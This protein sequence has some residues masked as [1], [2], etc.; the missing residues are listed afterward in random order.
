[1]AGGGGGGATGGGGGARGGSG[2]TAGGS[3]G[4]T[5]GGGAGGGA[6]G[7]Q[8]GTG[9][10][11]GTGGGCSVAG[12]TRVSVVTAGAEAHGIS[13]KPSISA[14]GRFV[15]FSSAAPD[16]VAGDTNNLIDIFVHDRM[17]GQTT[18]VSVDSTGAQAMG[19]NS[20]APAISADGRFVVFGSLA[21]NL[22]AADG[23]GVQDVFVHD[24]TTHA[25]TRVSVNDSGAE[26]D[27]IS[28]QPAISGDGRYVA[29]ASHATNFVN[30]ILATNIFVRDRTAGTTTLASVS[31]GGQPANENCFDTAISGDGQVVVF[32]TAAPLVGG[33]TIGA[34]IFARD[35][36]ANTTTRVSNGPTGGQATGTCS[37]PA[38]TPDGRYV[39]FVSDA[40]DL[41]ANDTNSIADIFLRDRT[42]QTTTRVSVDSAGAEAMG[43]GAFGRPALS[44]DAR[45][46]VFHG[47][48]ATV[49]SG[50]T[51]DAT[52]IFLRDRTGG[53][54]VRINLGPG[55][56]QATMSRD[57]VGAT[58]SADGTVIA[59]E[60][61]ATNL[62][63]ADGNGTSDVFVN[64]RACR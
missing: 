45:T 63:A 44:A 38:I 55:G 6:G 43:P 62:I 36:T 29:F 59:F 1:V 17:T 8:A 35:R 27:N 30:G 32:A 47:L 39:V 49:V 57:S 7:G 25:T 58:I 2:G 37:Q 3:G 24:L 51:N 54:T 48:S 20:S 19:G 33:V 16:L 53:T 60:S 21:T 61:T 23:N 14:D 46:I 22:V 15:A 10:A 34:Q 41:V 56:T 52:D 26:G 50:D 11:G 31:N 9:G 64:D 42:G 4:A 12:V 5:G 13:N 18:R 28:S 40:P